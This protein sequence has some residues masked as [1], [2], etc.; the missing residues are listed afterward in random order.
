MTYRFG[1]VIEEAEVEDAMDALF[2]A[3]DDRA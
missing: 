2:N 1:A 3:K